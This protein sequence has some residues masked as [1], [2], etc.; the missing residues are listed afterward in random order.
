M[1]LPWDE[2]KPV[3]DII[4]TKKQRQPEKTAFALVLA[5]IVVADRVVRIDLST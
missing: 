1:H 4:K 5:L 3:G 2:R